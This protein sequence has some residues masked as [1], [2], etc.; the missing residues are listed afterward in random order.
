MDTPLEKEKILEPRYMNSNSSLGRV[1]R[2][3]SKM[4]ESMKFINPL[5]IDLCEYKNG[6]KI[7]DLLTINDSSITKPSKP[8]VTE[9]SPR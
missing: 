7:K 6:P 3:S 2:S 1:S 4:D 8:C 9:Q 5:E